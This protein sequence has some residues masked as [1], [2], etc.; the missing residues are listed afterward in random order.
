VNYTYQT[1]FNFMIN[2]YDSVVACFSSGTPQSQKQESTSYTATK[3]NWLSFVTLLVALFCFS[4]L[5]SQNIFTDGFEIGNTDQGTSVSNWTQESSSG[6]QIWVPN[7]SQTSYNR[8]PR[9]GSFNAY[10]RY[11][12][13]DWLF[14]SVEL[15]GGVPY[16]LSV[17]ARQD[18]STTANAGITLKYGTV[19]SAAGMTNS[20]TANVGV[21]NSYTEVKGVFTPTTSGTYY[22]GILG[23][24]NS[25]PWYIS[26]DDVSLDV[27]VAADA[28]PIT[29]STN[30]I[31]PIGMT[32]NWVDNSTNETAF[33]VYG[34]VDNITFTQMGTDVASTSVASVGTAYSL[35]ITGLLP[36]TTYYFRVAAV[37]DA[38]SAYLTGT[39]AT[40]DA[41]TYYWVGNTG[42][43][44][45]S[46]A[47]W[48]TAADNT[49]SPRSTPDVSDILVVDGAGTTPGAATTINVEL[50]SFT[51]GQFK[52]TSNTAL[53]LLSSSTT[54][55]TITIMGSPGDDF[56]IESGSTL[57]LTDA[58]KAVAF[59]FT[60]DGNTGLIAGFYNAAGSSSNRI[61]STGGTNTLVTVAATGIITS[62]VN[63][64]SGALIGSVATLIFENGSNW[65]HQN[66][67]TV[68]YIPTATWQPSATSTLNGNTTGTSLTSSSPDLGNL[69]VNTAASSATLS[70]FTSNNR[71]IQGDLTIN[72]TGTGKFRALTSGTLTINGDLIVSGGTFEVASSTGTLNVLGNVSLT[73]GVFDVAQGGASNLKVKG[74]FV[75]TGGSLQQTSGSGTLEFN[76]VVSQTFTPATVTAS[77]FLNIRVNN[78]SGVILTANLPVKNVTIS[79]GNLT[80]AGLLSYN[81]TA[82]LLTYN[83]AVAQAATA[84]EF[85]SA[86]GPVSLTIDNTATAPNNVVS[87]PFTRTLVGT[88][89]T[90]NLTN[91]ILDNS[92]YVLSVPNT[93]S[94]SVSAGSATSYVKG[95][96]ERSLP[97]NLSTNATYSFPVGKSAFNSFELINPLTNSTAGGVVAR[98]EVVDAAT[99]GTAGNLISALNTDNYW[100][101]STSGGTG[102]NFTSS[103]IKLNDTRNAADAIAASAT[104][105]GA[106]DMVGGLVSTVTPTSIQTTTP[107]T[108]L[109]GFYVMAAK[110]APVLTNLAITPVGNRCPHVTRTVTVN[111]AA[112]AGA[113]TGVQLD[114]SVNGG[115]PI[116]V[117]MN[118]TSGNTWSGI[119]PTVAPTNATVT[120]SV[121]ATDAN[122]L[123]KT[124]SGTSYTDGG[125]NT[126]IITIT[127]SVTS[128]CGDGGPVT[129]TASSTD[130]PGVSYIWQ[131]L[132]S[133]VTLS[134]NT[135]AT[136]IANITETANFKVL[137]LPNDGGCPSEAYISI[138]VYPLPTAIVTTSADGVCP[139]TSATIG[140][141]LSAG[142]FTVI[143]IPY[144]ATAPPSYAVD[145]M[146]N[147]TATVPLSG[148]S[149]DDGGWSNIPLG[150]NFDY[151]GTTFS[152]IS[153]GT[154]GL[155]M[156]GTP[157]GYGT[158]SGQL[159]QYSF[160]GPPYFPN[161]ANP[162]N[163]IA[164]M[165]TDMH[166][167]TN[168]TDSAITYWTEGYAPNRTFVIEYKNVH[169]YF[170]N[171]KATVQCRLVETVGIVEIHIFEKS[172]SN[173]AIVGLQDATKTIG[174]V[175]PG[176]A[177]GS[178]TVSTP[179]AYRF[180]PPA[181]YN[182]TWTATDANGTTTIASG[183]NIFSQTVTP[184]IT[185]NYS[186]SYTNQTSGCTNAPG[187]AEVLMTVLSDTAPVGVNTI[188]SSNT[189]CL[190]E[191][192]ALS[193]DYTGIVD[194]L[195]FQWQSSI[196]NGATWQNI[197]AATTTTTTVTPTVS[198]QYRCQMISCA[199]T[200]GY[201]SVSSVAFTNNIATTT[202]ATRCGPGS[203]S[204]AATANAGTTI[205]WYAAQAGGT[206]IGTG[207]TFTTPINSTS[208]TYYASAVSTTPGITTL[209]AGATNSSSTGASFF[210]GFWGGAK[211]QY[212]IKATELAAAGLSA[213]SITSLGFE[214]TNSGQTYQGFNVSLGLT[215]SETAPSSTFI[216]NSGLS[217]VY[218]GTE[219]NGGYTPV[220][221]TVN[222]LV[223]GTGTGTAS[224]FTWD[225]TSNVVVSISWTRVPGAFTAT[226]T[227]MKVDNVGFVASAYRQRDNLTPTAM[228]DETSVSSTA[229]NRPRFT[230]NGQVLCASPRVPVTVTVTPTPALIL[231]SASTSICEGTT[232]TT[233]ITLVSP[234]TDFDTYIWSPST[235]VSGDASMGWTF[236]PSVSTNYTLT[237][238]QTSGNLCI[239][240]TDYSFVILPIPSIDSATA[241]AIIAC[242]GS[243][244]DLAASSSGIVPG[245]SIASGTGTAYT[246]SSGY[247]T[248]FGNYWRQDWSQMVYTASEL[249]AMGL[250]EGDITSLVFNIGAVPSP[251]TINGYSI[252]L[253]ATA[254]NT[255]SDFETTALTTVFG[256]VDYSVAASGDITITFSTPFNWD[257]TS[258]III[259]V[260]GS[261]A[262]GSANAT[263]QYSTT[264]G[265][266]VVYAYTSS[267][268]ST[269]WTSNPSA[270]TSTRRPNVKFGGQI[271]SDTTA[272][273][274]WTWS[275]GTSTVLTAAS[276]SVT[277]PASAT[278]TYTVT[279][280]NVVPGC[281]DS[282]S[283]TVTA[284]PLPTAP[285]TLAST[286]CGNQVPTASVADTNSFTTPTYNWYDAATAGNLLQTGTATTF[287]SPVGVT[288]TL[289]VSVINPTTLCESLRTP[290]TITVTSAPAFSISS[291]S[292]TICNG[293][294]TAVVTATGTSSF[295]DFVWSPAVGVTGDS[296]TGWIFN[297]TT[298]TNYTL[299]ASQSSGSLCVNTAAFAVVVNPL[300]N[301]TLVTPSTLSACAGSPIQ[302]SANIIQNVPGDAT[303]GSGSSTGTSYDAIFYHS[304]GGNKVQY[305]ITAAELA[306]LG[307]RDGNITA[308]GIDMSSVTSQAY[309]GF[310]V[311]M[312]STA[313][314]NMSAGINS[315]ATF[316][317]VYSSVSYTPITGVNT[318]NFTTPFDWDGSSNI[319]IQFCWSNSNFGGQSNYAKVDTQSY[320]STAYYRADNET[321]AEICGGTTAT[322][323]TS[324]RPMFI[325][326]AV[327]ESN[328]NSNY[329]WVWSDGTSTVL[330]GEAG[331]V[332][333]PSA[334]TT[335]YTVTATDLV[336]G[337]TN[338][339]N[340][341]QVVASLVSTIAPVGVTTIAPS[342]ICFG[343]PV[344]LSLSYTGVMEGLLFQWQSS[345]D[346]GTTWVDIAT[347]TGTSYTVSQIVPTKYRC[348][349]ISCGGTPGYSSVANV[350]FT[351]NILATS[352]A[353]RC[354]TGNASIFA[355]SSA[356]STVN[357]YAANAGGI[358]LSS[359]NEFITPSITSTTTY[360]A[361]AVSTTPGITTLGAGATN[362]SSTGASFFPGFWG[363]AKTQYII[364][365][366]ELAAAGLSAGSITSLGFE[367]TNSG[368]T[369]QGFNVSL[370]LTTSETA[371]SSTF[372]PN[373]GLSLVYTGTETNGGYTPVADTVNNLVFGTGTGTASSFTWDGTSNVVVSI[374]WTRVPGAFTATSTTMK[375]DNVGFVASAYRQRDNLTPTAMADE[376][377]VSSTASN[378]PRFT[379]NGQVLCASPRVPVTVTV[380]PAPAITLSS[381][382]ASI[383][384]GSA[385]PAITATGTSNYNTYV[386]SPA[387][388]VTGNSTTGWV[389]NPITTTNYTLTASQ[390]SGNQCITLA[391]FTVNVN[392]LPTDITIS[393]AN[394]SA[395]VGVVLPLT[396]TGGVFSSN[397]FVATMDVLPTNFVSSANATVT[398]NTD[399][400]V[401]G[402]GSTL[403]TTA[404]TSATATFALNQNI[405]LTAAASASVTFSHIAATEA[406]WDFGYVEYST[407]GGSTWTTF[408]P[409]NYVGTAAASVFNANARF[410]KASYSDWNT[411]FTS[412]TS[413][414][415][416]GPAT[417]LWKSE[418]FNIP[419]AA[420][421]S[422]QFRIRFRYTTDSSTNY[423][424][425]LI[426]DVKI[427]ITQSNITWSPV[428]DLYTNATATIPYTAGT[429]ASTVYVLP[430][431]V[432]PLTYVATSTNGTTTCATTA[433]I[434]LSD[435]VSPVVVTRPVTIQLDAAGTATVTAAQ[436]DNGSSDNCSI[437]T[438]V[439]SPDTFTCANVGDNTVSLT[440]T[441]ASGNES[442]ATAVV[443]VQDL[444]GPT[445]VTQP[446]TVQLNA[447][448]TASITAAQIDNGSSDACGIATITVS[449]NTFTC[450]NIGANTVTLTVT[451]VNGNSSTA[452]AVVTIIV[453]F[454]TA[455]DN[456]LDG[457]PDNC[458]DDDDNDGVLDI[459]DNC[460]MQAN[461]DQADNDGDGEGDAC[462]DDDDNDGILD[463]FDNCPFIYNPG[464]EDIDNDGIGDI[465]DKVEINV[466]EAITPDGDGVNDTWFIN[467]IQNYPNNSV[468]VYNRWG[469]LIFSKN[470]YQNDWNGSFVNNGNNIPDA[471]SYYYQIDLDGNGSIDYDGWIYITK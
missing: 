469:D 18:G 306:A 183:T 208:T 29:F 287:D 391:D 217:L 454:T 88:T 394:P 245:T 170:S 250:S 4:N 292:A 426:D 85:P 419:T 298:S 406:S 109:D 471:S 71:T 359:G 421:T 280:T 395:C 22:I 111:V 401:Q 358:P 137:G 69:I 211:T 357:W 76:G 342:S 381:A 141:G 59:A 237:A 286:H 268:N 223:F 104:L 167:G 233:P 386:W 453:D 139:G 293:A 325:F 213:G 47:N 260:R 147:G 19:A 90:L 436:V 105:T 145:I 247:P 350:E 78:D 355:L 9:T 53:T 74:N 459:N 203:V 190:G 99:G 171:P 404:S 411:V 204:I 199:G 322:G 282:Q 196:D 274:T 214:P 257:G 385:T 84:S 158:S 227:T 82:S 239:S 168:N 367:P 116:A 127:P 191:S 189:I 344:N 20:I 70:A 441:D 456:D 161:T 331:L 346:N 122:L 445:V 184:I 417:S 253:G 226:S 108:T 43:N 155:L 235:G 198:T 7:S 81:A 378:R 360:Y 187:S 15:T 143:P 309:G 153:A 400:Y 284:N 412:S 414:P 68:N 35:P 195:T 144:A 102:A 261:G 52:V 33:R 442:F 431:T 439:V 92:T 206:E 449:P 310:A 97:A 142:N 197:A 55:R 3:R 432:A 460:P 243:T 348:Q 209:G 270:T 457:I 193:M 362:S 255:L 66:T 188:A 156:F 181:N 16:K 173:N 373:S 397:A 6:T 433:T 297:P 382:S 27:A 329:A 25:S 131:P 375:V 177:G 120:W 256:P 13:T 24:I 5:F 110:A 271:L 65:I 244:I 31:T 368:Q 352:D 444:V 465:C 398:N 152:T 374:S 26:I 51:I 234:A 1:N 396:T 91:G 425:W 12:N 231:S 408:T 17:Y 60:G 340:S 467:N 303:L 107:I 95:A 54:T 94:S 392:A 269:F 14:R 79:L 238:T 466:S 304:Y 159:G 87:V 101:V 447:A 229:S 351:N 387:S 333:M 379:F 210:P 39:Q 77:S 126:S 57:N 295:N 45:G 175:A 58:S 423:L 185:T 349:M 399:Y 429:S 202:D 259:D 135:G 294:S 46:A 2:N 63:S 470:N 207:S 448:G 403:F 248:F 262:F 380:T 364:K 305:L 83:G 49:G 165:A 132:T 258:N 272:D 285:S 275:D 100:S 301:I 236:N 338:V 246:S 194:G 123:T 343:E 354:G 220:A 106:Y 218:T 34:S 302:L 291:S 182:T 321:S 40:A 86:N 356:G 254:N 151:F 415:G 388:G 121:T 179:E 215:T 225:G 290:V 276:G 319:I 130:I 205:N 316:S 283:V 124:Q 251:T 136:T 335:T 402:N 178:W 383:C 28:A 56:V 112:G 89:G 299:T 30:A 8:S 224:S 278:T 42:G 369:Y 438:M 267:N 140:S 296:S 50:S 424:G 273:Y 249:Q 41:A 125:L 48:N 336:T 176:R 129:L 420:L 407:N 263:T 93:A 160:T 149:L 332:N 150:F 157:P 428:T 461:T 23:T 330:T 365:A 311:S 289:Y 345:I 80:G 200:P 117:T 446:V 21:G 410:T 341:A 418:T 327:V 455:G 128:F 409:A 138:G 230:F 464:Q 216:P 72:S 337:C 98:V 134:T 62:S 186:I 416:V 463:G 451:D 468:K 361:S 389:F 133:G 279:A 38:E 264:T 113:V 430:T 265:N 115:T 11:G 366:T 174:A 413:T 103:N 427:Q 347:A 154:N 376:T 452:T 180:A 67:T 372:I 201:S 221:D 222:N 458:D 44:F 450:A 96:L 36:S 241:S 281:S 328:A 339:P 363:G 166:M 163:I 114:Y 422:S 240:N 118:N 308:L 219:T 318:F 462:D 162:G 64:S 61:T 371:P 315:T 228:A 242:E 377:S 300:P 435:A 192:V 277:L 312:A 390:S 320:V 119:I 317:S 172:F 146:N 323:T 307:I 10:L 75:Q 288:T 324:K 164:L 314:T 384:V 313:D 326:N 443:T 73:G 212:I 437:A 393:P 440:V 169:G 434:T 148:G 252:S 32:L 232:A 334:A 353:T 405:D 37:V 266:T 370:G